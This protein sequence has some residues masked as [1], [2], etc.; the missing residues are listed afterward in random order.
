VALKKER[1]RKMTKS[2]LEIKAREMLKA[3]Q[4]Y[5]THVRIDILIVLMRA[6]KPL[7]Q[8]QIA[9]F[10][11]EKRFDKVTI[12]RTLESLLDVGLVHKAFMDKRAWHFELADNCTEQQ[13]HPHF[14]CTSCGST[15]CLMGI[16]LPMAK[17]PHK[18][19]VIQRQQVRL[20]GLCPACA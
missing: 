1:E 15:H 8:D 20:E 13:C 19:F 10:S 7:S 18:G 16:S 11:G 5:C 4:L 6:G 3:A 14:T 9:S 17:S 12:Y 2:N